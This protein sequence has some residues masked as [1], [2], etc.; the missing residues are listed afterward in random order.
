MCEVRT[1]EAEM[2]VPEGEQVS[3]RIF[4]FRCSCGS[5]IEVKMD[6]EGLGLVDGPDACPVCKVKVDL[7][8][9]WRTARQQLGVERKRL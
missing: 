8:S 7:V 5:L 6:F 2:P 9:V 4:P 3:E 1:N